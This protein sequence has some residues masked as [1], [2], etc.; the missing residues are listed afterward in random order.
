LS[1]DG[2]TIERLAYKTRQ[3][4]GNL[5][6]LPFEANLICTYQGMRRLLYSIEINPAGISI[7][8]IEFTQLDTRGQ[9]ASVK[10]AGSVRFK[11]VGT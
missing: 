6:T 7:D 5:V 10:I 1:V 9:G 2:V 8:Q 4:T 11:K 3:T